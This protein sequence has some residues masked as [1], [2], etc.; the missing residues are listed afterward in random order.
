MDDFMNKEIKIT[1]VLLKLFLL[2]AV[3]SLFVSAQDETAEYNY[4]DGSNK[5]AVLGIQKSFKDEPFH[6][7]DALSVKIFPDTNA[8]PNGIYFIDDQ[9]FAEFPIIGLVQVSKFTEIELVDTLKKAYLNHLPYPNIQVRPLIRATLLGGFQRPGLY[10]VDPRTNLWSLIQKSGGPLRGD[11]I[12]KVKWIRNSLSIT[13]NITPYYESG[14][15]LNSIGFKSGDQIVVTRRPKRHF[16]EVF[17]RDVLPL[18]TG[19]LT[20]LTAAL[21]G[22]MAFQV[23]KNQE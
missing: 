7:G 2:V 4:E 12:K 17:L 13:D 15:S 20:T 21:S 9:G 6:S 8:F 22:Y 14:N 10:W 23:Y 5:K 19:T 18:I 1:G 16:G 11:G 3:L